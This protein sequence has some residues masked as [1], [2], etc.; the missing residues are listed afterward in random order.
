MR[1]LLLLEIES[2]YWGDYL[3]PG[4]ILKYWNPENAVNRPW[5]TR[6]GCPQMT[7]SRTIDRL[8]RRHRPSKVT[9]ATTIRGGQF[10]NLLWPRPMSPR[11]DFIGT[12]CHAHEFTVC[13]KNRGKNLALG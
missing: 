6:R 8:W 5:A 12:R 10:P 13:E 7:R 1:L 11:A 9:L 2:A 4:S 3:L